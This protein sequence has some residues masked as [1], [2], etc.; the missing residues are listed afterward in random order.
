MC[1]ARGRIRDSL[2]RAPPLASSG[3]A[4]SDI[5]LWPGECQAD[6]LNTCSTCHASA[7][8]LG[9]SAESLG[10]FWRVGWL[11]QDDGLMAIGRAH[12]Q[13]LRYEL[14]EAIDQHAC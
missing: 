14:A 4:L 11:N 7:S 9:R 3:P 5:D 13:L 1:F 8:G 6:R 12:A 2:W 10:R